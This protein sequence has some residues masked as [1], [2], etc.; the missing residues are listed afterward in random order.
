MTNPMQEAV[1]VL[2][3][4][5]LLSLKQFLENERYGPDRPVVVICDSHTKRFCYPVL[6]PFLPEGHHC[7]GFPAGEAYKHLDTCRMLWQSLSEL[8]IGRGAL[9]LN[10]G[11]GIT[12]DMG[13]FVAATYK[14][15]LG[16]VHVP[17]SLMAM[18]DACIGGKL[19][20]NLGGLKNH[21]GVF[22]Q[23]IGI[24]IWLDFLASLPQRELYAGFAEIIKHHLIK[25]LYR[26]QQLRH[27]EDLLGTDMQALVQ[28]SIHI[29]QEIVGRDPYDH[30][31][32]QTL[33]FGHTIGHAIESFFLQK[34]QALLH[35]EAV[36][37]GIIMESWLSLQK[38]RI[39]SHDMED[40]LRL[41]GRFFSPLPMTK[42][43]IPLIMDLLTHDKKRLKKRV[44]FSLLKRIGE[45]SY[46]EEVQNGLVEQALAYY[47]SS[48][49]KK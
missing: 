35:G 4:E 3:S 45:A 40:I 34:N 36:A 24:Y 38:D 25:D 44:H 43:D 7:I 42:G 47:I 37:A 8:K 1:M 21:V 46:G 14:R 18:V 6:R 20:V 26:W 49:Y 33:N 39:E 30:G 28:H 29:K 9:I 12:C 16:F 41:I 19:G 17:T 11:G 2:G 32:R 13:G 10:L 27:I 48:S 5:A 22:A 23:P 31:P 15:G